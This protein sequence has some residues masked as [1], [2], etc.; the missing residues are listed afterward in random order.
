VFGPKE[1]IRAAS[2]STKA[3]R[4][5]VRQS[6]IDVTIKL[7]E[8]AS[9]VLCP[10]QHFE[11]TS[12]PKGEAVV[13]SVRHLEPDSTNLPLCKIAFSRLAKRMSLASAKLASDSGS[14]P[15]IETIDNPLERGSGAPDIRNALKPVG[16]RRQTVESSS[17]GEEVIVR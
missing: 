13:P 5:D 14:A 4:L 11:G 3:S 6:T 12:L 8:I 9:Y 15:R 2:A 17:F 10:E 16:A 1:A 7:G